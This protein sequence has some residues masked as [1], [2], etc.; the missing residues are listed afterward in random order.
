MDAGFALPRDADQRSAFQA[1]GAT[2]GAQRY[3]VRGA[4]RRACRS[5]DRRSRP[6]APSRLLA[7]PWDCILT[8]TVQRFG[9]PERSGAGIPVADRVSLPCGG[10]GFAVLPVLAG[11]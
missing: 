8:A 10:R 4:E 1:G 2:L 6:A 3:D 7:D 5:G 11:S 9:R